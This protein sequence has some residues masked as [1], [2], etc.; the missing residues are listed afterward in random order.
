MKRIT[1]ALTGY[2]MRRR[3]LSERESAWYRF[4]IL[5]ALELILFIAICLCIAAAL[6]VFAEAA[7]FLAIFIP[8]RSYAGGMHMKAYPTCLIM[9]CILFTGCMILL[10]QCQIPIRYSFMI[11]MTS[12]AVIEITGPLV[13]QDRFVSRARRKFCR[14]KLRMIVA[15]L[16]LISSITLGINSLYLTQLIAIATGVVAA[17]MLAEAVHRMYYKT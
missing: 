8:T 17:G 16:L 2:I 1:E 6:H 4:G 12:L 9:S 10:I 11:I 3:H 7:M 13:T 14:R 5:V 15:V